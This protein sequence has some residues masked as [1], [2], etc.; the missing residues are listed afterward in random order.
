MGKA[1]VCDRC[2]KFYLGNDLLKEFKAGDESWRY[3]VEFDA[4]P[5]PARKFELC[6]DCLKSLCSWLKQEER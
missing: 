1:I 3:S 2:G 4:H 5:Y 6:S